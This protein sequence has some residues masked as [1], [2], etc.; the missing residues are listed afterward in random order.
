M[1]AISMRGRLLRRLIGVFLLGWGMFAGQAMAAQ[2]NGALVFASPAEAAEAL[3][4][5]LQT[6]RKTELF[7]IL[8]KNT[9]S[10]LESGDAAADAEARAKLVEL[11]GRKHE[12][13]MDGEAHASLVI[14]DDAWLFPFPLVKTGSSWRFDAQAG[15]N[16]VLARRIGKN[17]LSAVQASL[18]IV[19]AQREYARGHNAGGLPEYARKFVSSPG[20]RDGLYW[21]TV[22]GET[23]SPLGPLAARAAAGARGGV[24]PYHGYLFRMLDAQGRHASGGA[25]SYVLDGR[26]VGGF[27]VVAYPAKYGVSGIMTFM[28]NHDGV[29]YEQNLGADTARIATGMK[30]FDPGKGWQQFD[31]GAAN[32]NKR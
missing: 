4:A 20:M 18:A 26:M 17:E 31:N 5:A 23:P 29:V 22:A 28:V 3:M 32:G 11:Y 25:Y 10:W 2:Q 14:G 13:L 21:E 1:D 24:V 19:D 8:G 6:H 12:I 30:M 15:K 7:A 27:A 16:E 9:R